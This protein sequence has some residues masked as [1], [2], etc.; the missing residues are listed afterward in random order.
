MV[1]ISFIVLASLILLTGVLT[2]GVAFGHSGGTS[3]LY[4]AANER[5]GFGVTRGIQNVPSSVLAALHAGWYVNWGTAPN[6]PHPYGLTYVQII[7]LGPDAY[8]PRGQALADIVRRNPGTLWLVGN[9]PDSPFQDNQTPEQYVPKYHEIYYFI[10]SVD[11]TAQVAIGGVIQ[12]TPLRLEY[13]D[14]IWDLYR[15]QYGEPMPVDV[16]N[17]H[18]FILREARVYCSPGG[19]WG[20]YIPPGIPVDCGVQYTIDDHDDMDIFRQQIIRFRQWMKE[21]GQQN[22]PLIVSEY[23]ILFPE[24]L[25]FTE[26]RVRKFMLNTFD[27]FMNARDP[28][29][30]YPADD[31]HLV[32]QWAWFSL[33]ET[34][35]EWGHTHSALYDPDA[36]TLT[37]LGQAFA[38]YAQE[39]VV[40]Y[41]D[42]Y[43]A[44]LQ[45]TSTTPHT[46]GSP[47]PLQLR[48]EVGNHGNKEVGGTVRVERITPDGGAVLVGS[49]PVARVPIRYQGTRQVV[50][51]DT[52]ALD[53]SPHY[54][55]RVVQAQDPRPEN[56]VAEFSVPLDLQVVNVA[57]L[58]SAYGA[59][60]RITVT[61][62]AEVYNHTPVPLRRIPVDM[63][64]EGDGT[65][66]FHARGYVPSVE[67]AR[68]AAATITW[69]GKPGVYTVT[70]MVDP[71]NQ[72]EEVDEENNRLRQMLV[73]SQQRMWLP[74]VRVMNHGP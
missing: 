37:P 41:G 50:M 26:E 24:E 15:Q 46:F 38:A 57:A 66:P 23:G 5:L 8:T 21:K 30:G 65:A 34:S 11:P 74:A 70:A 31:Y 32:Q 22:K 1:R 48:V 71:D 27:F 51:T 44:A 52:V 28:D 10:K 68:T 6:A 67:P 53:A 4:P 45:A 49:Q 47:G 64:V 20:A 14:R 25:G 72:M 63:W 61:L 39:R 62:R 59:G 19:I 40:S 33:D 16:W 7:S 35:F 60:E 13:L 17:V 69:S 73:L 29:L 3:L 12:A 9:E 58:G 18:N 42:L 2:S 54:R 36:G 56:N 43:P 55:V